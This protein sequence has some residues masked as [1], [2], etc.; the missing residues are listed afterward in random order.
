MSAGFQDGS[1]A[2]ALFNSPMGVAVKSGGSLYV[3]DSAND[4]IRSIY[5]GAVT[6]VAGNGTPGF[7]DGAAATAELHGPTG[8]AVDQSGTLY[9]A[10]TFNNRIRILRAPGA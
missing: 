6:T 4:C 5:M 1:T 2:T 10:D 3:A 9:I 8:L 7:N